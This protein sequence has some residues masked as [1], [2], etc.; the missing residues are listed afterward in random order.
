MSDDVQVADDVPTVE[1]GDAQTDAAKALAAAPPADWVPGTSYDPIAPAAP[2]VA[3]PA[4]PA[5]K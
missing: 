4:A 5:A 2:A 1:A 3:A